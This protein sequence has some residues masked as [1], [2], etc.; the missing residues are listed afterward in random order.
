M[1]KIIITLFLFTI[2]F[3]VNAQA[4][5]NLAKFGAFIG[6][7]N[8][9]YERVLDKRSAVAISPALGVFSSMGI[10]YNIAGV[11]AEYRYYLPLLKKEAPKGFYLSTGAG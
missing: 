1:R 6:S 2:T 8:V 7:L 11:G 3:S 4:Y 9:S 10:K 5:K